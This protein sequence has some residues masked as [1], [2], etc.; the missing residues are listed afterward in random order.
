M[1]LCTQNPDCSV[2]TRCNPGE[3]RVKLL[4]SFDFELII[5]TVLSAPEY[6]L[7]LE[8]V[9]G[10][11]NDLS[12]NPC[13]FS[14]KQ[15]TNKQ[16]QQNTSSWHRSIDYLVPSL[17]YASLRLLNWYRSIDYLVPSL[18]YA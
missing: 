4:D 16:T 2:G 18:P 10:T 6:C 12:A 17:P 7:K 15:Q 13:H 3:R 1:M 9:N 14:T 5:P 8:S 11:Q